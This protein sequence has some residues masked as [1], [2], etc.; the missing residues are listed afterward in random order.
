ME[1]VRIIAVPY[2]Y[3]LSIRRNWQDIQKLYPDILHYFPNYDPEFLLSRKHFWE[4]F[5]SLYYDDAK[6]IIQNERKRKF[7]KEASKKTKEIS[8]SK[9]VL[10]LI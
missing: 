8:I 2:Y 9:D 10:D 7:K 3:S 6:V 4:V 5:A 1:S